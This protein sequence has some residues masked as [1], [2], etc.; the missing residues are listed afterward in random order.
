MI[1]GVEANSDNLIISYYDANGKIAYMK[2]HIPKHEMFNWVEGKK[3]SLHRNWNG[4]YLDKSIS[5]P[6][7]LTRTRLEELLIEKLTPEERDIIYDFDNTPKK[8]FIDIEIQL[9]SDE[10]P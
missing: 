4:K 2:K 3:P 5:D 9:T 10:F 1:I 6:K 8:D 7:W